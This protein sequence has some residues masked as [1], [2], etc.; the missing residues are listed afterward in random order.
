[1]QEHPIFTP[2]NPRVD[3][4]DKDRLEMLIRD[5]EWLKGKIAGVK[6]EGEH[7]QLNKPTL[8]VPTWTGTGRRPSNNLGTVGHVLQML[9][10]QN[11]GFGVPPD[12]PRTRALWLVPDTNGLVSSAYP[13]DDIHGTVPGVG[14][15]YHFDPTG[16]NEILNFVPF[17][18][19]VDYDSDFEVTLHYLWANTVGSNAWRRFAMMNEIE[20]GET[21]SQGLLSGTVNHTV[22]NANTMVHSSVP[23][24]VEPTAAI[25]GAVTH[26]ICFEFQRDGNH[27]DDTNTGTTIITAF[28]LE[29]TAVI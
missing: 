25:D 3:R 27:A 23:L 1:M 17:I 26:S 9:D 28:W 5:V 6:A 21:I 22:T 8:W 24:T 16:E 12:N 18:M 11:F 13:A 7:F 20:H 19:P 10:T 14:L 29:Y 2:E 15:H 4:A